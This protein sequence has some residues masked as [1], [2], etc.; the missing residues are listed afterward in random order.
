[1]D[2]YEIYHAL[3]NSESDDELY[4]LMDKFDT[5]YPKQMEEAQQMIAQQMMALSLKNKK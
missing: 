5:L 2:R 3:M 1:M 4:E